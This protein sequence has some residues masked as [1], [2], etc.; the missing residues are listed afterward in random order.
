MSILVGL[1]SQFRRLGHQPTVGSE[2]KQTLDDFKSKC[3]P[4][5]MIR[6]T[7]LCRKVSETAKR[8]LKPERPNFL[9]VR[10]VARRKTKALNL[11]TA[12]KP[13]HFYLTEITARRKNLIQVFAQKPKCA[14][15]NTIDTSFCVQLNSPSSR[16]L[17]LSFII[18]LLLIFNLE[19]LLLRN[20]R[21]VSPQT[22]W[23]VCRMIL[24]V[25][26]RSLCS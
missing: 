3:K 13:G 8:S 4:G 11:Q 5:H 1:S 26:L 24:L 23:S 25:I 17:I 22:Y 19:V 9:T 14:A 6:K 2:R 20:C 16:E 15:F 21:K 7:N 10:T 12:K 18:S